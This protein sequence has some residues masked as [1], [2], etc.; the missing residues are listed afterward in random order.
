MSPFKWRKRVEARRERNH[1]AGRA[2]NLIGP[3]AFAHVDRLED[4]LR[5]DASPPKPDPLRGLARGGP[6]GRAACQRYPAT[7]WNPSTE[8]WYC[9]SCAKKINE[10]N[11]GLCQPPAEALQS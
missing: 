5:P 7:S 1:D 6:C 2:A 3:V 9:F 11:P 8:R 4:M 10:H